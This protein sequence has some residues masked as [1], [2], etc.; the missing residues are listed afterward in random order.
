MMIK[1]SGPGAGSIPLT[2]GSGSGSGRPK[3]MW[4]RIRNTA[5]NISGRER[6]PYLLYQYPVPR[7]WIISIVLVT[8]LQCKLLDGTDK[9]QFCR[10]RHASRMHGDLWVTGGGTYKHSPVPTHTEAPDPD[11]WYIP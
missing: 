11:T 8:E 7:Q 5:N 9:M 10:L 2:G 3:N 1:G 4:I 6:L